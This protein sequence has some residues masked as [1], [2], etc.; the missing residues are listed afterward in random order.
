M[1]PDNVI[2]IEE[3]SNMINIS[4]TVDFSNTLRI[5]IDTMIHVAEKG[6]LSKNF[7][8]DLVSDIMDDIYKDSITIELNQEVI[9]NIINGGDKD[10]E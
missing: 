2:K 7:L 1:A 10:G 3:Y 6:G 8:I 4:S 5:L 9:E